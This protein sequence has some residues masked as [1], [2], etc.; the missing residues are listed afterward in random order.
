M[1]NGLHVVRC[2]PES[3]RLLIEIGTC[4]DFALK[5][6]RDRGEVHIGHQ[7]MPNGP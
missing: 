3:S 1:I 6:Q 4:D 7:P 5:A 2:L